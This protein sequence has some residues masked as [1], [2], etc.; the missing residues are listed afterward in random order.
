MLKGSE[1][2]VTSEIINI[3]FLGLDN[4]GKSTIISRLKGLRVRF[5]FIK[6]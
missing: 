6:D 3:I 1:K 2:E 5:S 4:A